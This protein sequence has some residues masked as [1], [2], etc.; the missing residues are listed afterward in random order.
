MSTG[1]VILLIFTII[2][3]AVGVGLLV[4]GVS[5]KTYNKNGAAKSSLHWAA[6]AGGVVIAFLG[7]FLAFLLA[8]CP[9]TPTA[10]GGFVMLE[11]R[12]DLANYIKK[13][14]L[15]GVKKNGT[16]RFS[17]DSKININTVK[18][19]KDVPPMDLNEDGSPDS[20]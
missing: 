19:I 17:E 7:I 12:N 13:Y 4:H 9:K 5:S 14:G 6:I 8:K 11:V 20:K 10:Q 3:L 18:G 15:I 1:K 16:L 2:C